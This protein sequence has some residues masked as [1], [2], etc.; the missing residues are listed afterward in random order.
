MTASKAKKN[1]ENNICVSTMLKRFT[2]NSNNNNKRSAELPPHV[3]LKIELFEYRLFQCSQSKNTHFNF[4]LRQIDIYRIYKIKNFV[5]A[6]ARNESEIMHLQ[7]QNCV[8]TAIY[9]CIGCDCDCMP[10]SKQCNLS[11]DQNQ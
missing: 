9:T 3:D 10:F 11:H 6:I 4:I 1:I 7:F 8:T 2:N 5:A